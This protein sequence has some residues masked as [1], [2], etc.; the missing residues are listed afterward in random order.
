MKITKILAV[1]FTLTLLS[2]TAFSQK[3]ENNMRMEFHKNIF[4]KLN[5][6]DQQKDKMSELRFSH[7]KQMIDLKAALEKSRLALQELR[8]KDNFTRSE[9]LAAVKKI[10]Q[11]KN[12]IAIAEANNK[13]DMY[14]I[15]TPEQQKIWKK[16]IFNT[17]MH[18]RE[19]HP[20]MRMNRMQKMGK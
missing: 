6:T 7:K 8:S 15:L 3:N 14:E 9:V 19:K 2:G 11:A 16:N 17:R 5:L 4:E 18:N 20:M 13:M 1:I 12:D 10:N